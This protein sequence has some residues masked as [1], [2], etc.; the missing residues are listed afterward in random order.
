M[1]VV[2]PLAWWATRDG[3]RVRE[4]DPEAVALLVGRGCE[5]DEDLLARYPEKPVRE[6]KHIAS[7]PETGK[8]G[9]R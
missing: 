8:G 7:P 9:R 5:I 2:S 1:K 4:G 3:F 6:T